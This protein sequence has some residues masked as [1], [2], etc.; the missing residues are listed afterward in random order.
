MNLLRSDIGGIAVGA[1]PERRQLSRE[2]LRLVTT[3]GRSSLLKPC[4]ENTARKNRFERNAAANAGRND[5]WWCQW[6]HDGNDGPRR[7]DVD[8]DGDHIEGRIAF[9][10][11]ELKI[12]DVQMPQWNAFADTLRAN[13]QRMREM[14]T[15][16]MQ[17]G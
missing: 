15:T 5:G 11:A 17:G 6:S 7:H 9:L 12:T 4:R 2:M 1:R 10:K 8:D 14:R 13:A 16:M 3:A